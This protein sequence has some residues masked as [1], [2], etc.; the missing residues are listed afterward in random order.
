MA[1]M[2]IS[3]VPVGTKTTSISEYAV[4][5]VKQLEEQGIKHQVGPM[6]IIAEAPVRELLEA[7]NAMHESLFFSSDIQ[8]VVT[9][10]RIDDRRDT[11]HTME[12]KV[13]SIKEKVRYKK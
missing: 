11:E 6:G 9:T 5:A 10:I 12:R 4:D 8:R 2:E 7:A 1:I 3:L 13:K